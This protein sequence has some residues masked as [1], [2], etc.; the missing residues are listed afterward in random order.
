MEVEDWSR[1]DLCLH[2][3]IFPKGWSNDEMKFVNNSAT[4]VCIGKSFAQALLSPI[5][6]VG[7]HIPSSFCINEQVSLQ[8]TSFVGNCT[9][10][11]GKRRKAPSG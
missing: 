5:C 4:I 8:F 2:A 1:F 7:Q 10:E 6:S 9:R 3:W 11:F